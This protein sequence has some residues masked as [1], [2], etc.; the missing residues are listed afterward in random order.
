MQE[1][2]PNEEAQLKSSLLN[3]ITLWVMVQ[4]LFQWILSKGF[5]FKVFLLFMTFSIK[6]WIKERKS[7]L[8]K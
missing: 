6:W 5:I 7:K 4:Q 8:G 3:G 1:I 2:K